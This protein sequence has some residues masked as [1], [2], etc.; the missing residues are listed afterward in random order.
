MVT[1]AGKLQMMGGNLLSAQAVLLPVLC[2]IGGSL[3]NH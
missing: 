3:L 2:K 1:P